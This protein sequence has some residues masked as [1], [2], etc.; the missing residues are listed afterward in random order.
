MKILKCLEKYRILL[1]DYLLIQGIDYANYYSWARVD[2]MCCMCGRHDAAAGATMGAS[3]A[4]SGG[5]MHLCPLESL[6]HA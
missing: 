5:W 2:I 6:Q 1:N 4:H 3:G